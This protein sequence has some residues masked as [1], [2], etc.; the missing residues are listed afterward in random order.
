MVLI[1]TPPPSS[2]LSLVILRL[3]WASWLSRRE[4]TPFLASVRNLSWMS[5]RSDDSVRFRLVMNAGALYAAFS[6]LSTIAR[7]VRH[8]QCHWPY[9]WPARTAET[10]LDCSRWRG[11]AA[12]V[13]TVGLF[14]WCIRS[15]GTARPRSRRPF[16]RSPQRYLQYAWIKNM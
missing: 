10:A 11:T 9:S 3:T 2:T 12:A 14:R 1:H 4:A 5:W 8:E 16:A 6:A 15:C 7:R 13:R